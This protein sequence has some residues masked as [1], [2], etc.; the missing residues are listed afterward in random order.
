MYLILRH[1]TETMSSKSQLENCSIF[2]LVIDRSRKLCK[3]STT[4]QLMDLTYFRVVALVFDWRI[5]RSEIALLTE[6][7]G[8]GVIFETY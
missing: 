5:Q 7:K 3:R 1:A 2:F 8:V 4:C 6:I